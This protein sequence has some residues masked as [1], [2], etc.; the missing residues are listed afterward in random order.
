MMIYSG[1]GTHTGC[2]GDTWY[3]D[4]DLD[5]I[6]K[7]LGCTEGEN[8]RVLNVPLGSVLLFTNMTVHRS[9]ENLSDKIRWS[10]DWRWTVQKTIFLIN[11]IN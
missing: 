2:Q 1:L 3:V 10:M 6:E 7:E 9:Y 11:L 8:E 4:L 5:T